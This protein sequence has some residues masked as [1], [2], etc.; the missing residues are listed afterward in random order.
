MET[1]RVKRKFDDVPLGGGGLMSNAAIDFLKHYGVKGQKWGVRT[2]GRSGSSSSERIVKAKARS[3]T[4]DDLKKHIE[5]MRLEQQYS[6]LSSP[7]TK[8]GKKYAVDVL[9]QSGTKLIGAV[10]ATAATLAV[11]AAFGQ[12]TAKS[13]ARQEHMKAEEAARLARERPIPKPAGTT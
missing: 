13:S 11:T 8:A 1:Q 6:E 3:L 7:A 2:K 12:H 4:N 5:R 10:V 9:K